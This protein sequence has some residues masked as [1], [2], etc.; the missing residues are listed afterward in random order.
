MYVLFNLV[1]ASSDK[2]TVT[3]E[4]VALVLIY[5]PL[6]APTTPKLKPLALFNA[7]PSVA[8][9]LPVNVTVLLNFW[10]TL[11]NWLPF[12]ASVDVLLIVP[13]A[14]LVIF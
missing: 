2:S 12:T 4:P 14:T 13:G 9:V 8:P 7:W 1:F 11:Y 10:S 3:S 5:A 6:L